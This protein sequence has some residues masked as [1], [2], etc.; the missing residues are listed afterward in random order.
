MAGLTENGL[1]I[2]NLDAVLTDIVSDEKDLI[3]ENIDTRADEFL[4]QLNNIFAVAIAEQWELS[5]AVNDNFNPLKAEGKNLDDIG[6]ITGITRNNSTPSTTTKQV[7]YHATPGT[8]VPSSTQPVS[9]S[10]VAFLTTAAV[11]IQA[12]DTFSTRIV[13]NALPFGSNYSLTVNGDVVPFVSTGVL[14]TD[15]ANWV[16]DV[17]NTTAA[18]AGDYVANAETNGITISAGIATVSVNSL[19]GATVLNYAKETTAQAV[20]NGPT[21]A[22]IGKVNRLRTA[23]A[24]LTTSNLEA[25]S[26]GSNVESDE[27]YR[28]RILNDQGVSSAATE[29]ALT[30][31]I[32]DISGVSS[33][34]IV[35]NRT[36]ATVGSLPPKSFEAIVEGGDSQ[37]IAQ[38]IWDTQ[39][40]GIETYGTEPPFTVKDS[41]GND[42]TILFSRPI[43]VNLAIRVTYTEYDEENQTTDVEDVITPIVVDQLNA[44]Q[45]GVD[46]FTA[47]LYG[48][49]YSAIT[50]YNIN[51][52]EVQ[53]ITNPGDTPVGAWLTEVALTPN[54]FAAITS[55]DVSYI[56]V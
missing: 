56:E 15:I 24:G 22:A 43:A 21:I 51:A 8:V 53:V 49:I 1:E 17:N 55:I 3:D 18:L 35:Q 2:L 12:T 27:D 25:Y 16:I 46:V 32:G 52:I 6:S 31:A 19:I 44:L 39:P 47:R 4:G 54:E 30:R 20:I 13:V 14:A 36:F 9:E 38:T 7:F 33:V 11:T 5:Q 34:V 41:N 37:T 40:A 29:P 26:G 23:V 48:P 50:G 10:N 42:Q 28:V 45:S